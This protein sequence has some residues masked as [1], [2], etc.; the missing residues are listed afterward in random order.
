MSRHN[1]PIITTN[2]GKIPESQEIDLSMNAEQP[3]LAIVTDE[4][5]N[6]PVVKQ[7]ARELAFMEDVL[8]VIVGET[9][10]PNAENPVMAGC[11]GETV[12]LY[13]GQQYSIKRK[14]V[15]SLI[16]TTFRVSTKHFKDS[17]GC[18][19]TKMVKT[20]TRAY[21]ISILEDPAGE[22]GRRWLQHQL[23]NSH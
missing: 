20:P 19:Q 14:F 10:D 8:Q 6:S 12:K 2:D 7:Y 16:R 13:R 1:R 18:D 9:E 11:N 23:A 17:E 3:D 22:L 4:S 15:D 21:N 5:M